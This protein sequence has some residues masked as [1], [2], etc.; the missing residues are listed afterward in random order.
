VLMNTSFHELKIDLGNV[1]AINMYTENILNV[2]SHLK[3]HSIV[4]IYISF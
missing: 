4:M 1:V 3:I 2:N